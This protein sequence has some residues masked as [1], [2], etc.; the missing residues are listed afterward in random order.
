VTATTCTCDPDECDRD[1]EA[2][3]CF[4]ADC[5]SCL[6]SRP[7]IEVVTIWKA[8]DPGSPVEA[9]NRALWGQL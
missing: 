5:Q 8:G 1:G 4:L 6:A 3:E 2:D 9:L 7:D